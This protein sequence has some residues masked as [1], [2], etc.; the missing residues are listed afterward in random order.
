LIADHEAFALADRYGV[1]TE[2][3]RQALLMSSATNGALTLW[4]K[5]TMAWAED[6]MV[7]VGAMANQKG[8]GLPQAGL[9]REICRS[10]LPRRYDLS[11]YGV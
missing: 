3:L 4:G 6:D 2:V 7:I 8:I 11:E 1:D 9:N 10:L 5:Q